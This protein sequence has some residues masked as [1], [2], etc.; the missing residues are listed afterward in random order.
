LYVL[1]VAST[2]DALN[3]GSQRVQR[4][5]ASV[6]GQAQPQPK[7]AQPQPSEQAE[8]IVVPLLAP[9]NAP[10]PAWGRPSAAVAPAPAAEGASD[11]GDCLICMA[12]VLADVHFEPCGHKACVRCVVDLRKRSIFITT[13]GVPCPFCRCTIVRYAA[14]VG[15]DVGLQAR[16]RIAHTAPRAPR[17]CC[18]CCCCCCRGMRGCVWARATADALRAPPSH[19]QPAAAPEATLALR[20]T[21]PPLELRRTPSAAAARGPRVVDPEEAERMAHPRY[22]TQLCASWVSVRHAHSCAA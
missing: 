4:A 22:K 8:R 5:I 13:A 11:G 2:K 1:I 19:T 14:P 10:P 6:T 21:L 7:Q 3:E 18:C 16:P 17:C 20:V 12:G 9:S 15:V